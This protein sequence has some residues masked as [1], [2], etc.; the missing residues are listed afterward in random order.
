MWR[1]CRG[2]PES[3][4]TRLSTRPF[5]CPCAPLSRALGLAGQFMH[6]LALAQDNLYKR[7]FPSARDVTPDYWEWLKWRM[8]QV[9]GCGGVRRGGARCAEGWGGRVGS[10][11]VWRGCARDVT[12]DYWEDSAGVEG[13]GGAWGVCGRLQTPAPS[14]RPSP[15]PPPPGLA[16]AALCEQHDAEPVHAVA[17]AGAGHGRAQDHRRLCR[18]QLAAQGA[19]VC[20]ELAQWARTHAHTPVCMNARTHAAMHTHAHTHT[21][22]NARTQIHTQIHS[23]PRSRPGPHLPHARTHARM[24]TR[25]FHFPSLSSSLTSSPHL[26]R[27]PPPH[28]PG[29]PRPPSQGWGG[30]HRAHDRGHK[31]RADLRLRPQGGWARPPAG[32]GEGLRA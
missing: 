10:D 27:P 30:A 6:W 4:P 22:T 26:P 32:L 25:L 9:E 21:H 28:L 29:M 8:A 31:L 3:L 2:V 17:A 19:C 15:P 5:T 18:H 7:F 24:Q 11:E 14:L 13:C 1:G 20:V 16:P 23:L 12:P